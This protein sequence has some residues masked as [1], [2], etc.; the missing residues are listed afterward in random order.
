VGSLPQ[1]KE[2]GRSLLRGHLSARKCIG[3]I[4]FLERVENAYYFL[5]C[6]ILRWLFGCSS[7]DF[8]LEARIDVESSD[9]P[10][11]DDLLVNHRPPKTVALA[12]ALR[13]YLTWG[14]LQMIE[15]NGG[16]DGAPT[17]DLRSDRM[18]AGAAASA[19]QP[20]AQPVARVARRRFPNCYSPCRAS[21][22]K[23]GI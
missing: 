6:L 10:H 2:Y 19:N 5:H 14:C 18:Q 11:A 16:D 17:C 13:G 3:G 8:V 9:R 15:R 1:F 7:R 20:Q 23:F 12:K 21:Y 4:G 22:A